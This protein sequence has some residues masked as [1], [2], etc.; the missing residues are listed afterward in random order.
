M[1][2]GWISGDR[3]SNQTLVPPEPIDPGLK[4]IENK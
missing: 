2:P 3:G 1:A 4:K